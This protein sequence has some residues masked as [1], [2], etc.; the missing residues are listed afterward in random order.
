M[1]KCINEYITPLTYL[2]NSSIKQSIFPDELK[3]CQSIQTIDLYLFVFSKIFEK[4]VANCIIDFHDQND[5]FY[6]SQYGF[7]KYH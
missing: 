4:I 1:K 5:V 6:D 2:V 7:R 3:K